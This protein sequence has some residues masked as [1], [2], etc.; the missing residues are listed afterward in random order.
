MNQPERDRLSSTVNE[1]YHYVFDFSKK[2]LKKLSF[3]NNAEM[4]G[5]HS[6]RDMEKGYCIPLYLTEGRGG[7]HEETC[8]GKR[9]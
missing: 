6:Y 2:Q 9:L 7:G 5:R 4:S 3:G 8:E 1:K